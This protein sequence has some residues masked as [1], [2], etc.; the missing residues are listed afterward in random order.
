MNSTQSSSSRSLYRVCYR[1]FW[2]WPKEV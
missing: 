2:V 1:S